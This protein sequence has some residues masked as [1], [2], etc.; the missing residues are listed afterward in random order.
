[1]NVF[2]LWHFSPTDED[3][4]LIGVYSSRVN[5]LA[6]VQRAAEQSGFRDHPDIVEDTDDLG[7]FLDEQTLDE[8]D[9]T[10]GFITVD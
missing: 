1:M 3:G 5:A 8:D 4:K 9:W 6:A 2:L 7:F 10:E